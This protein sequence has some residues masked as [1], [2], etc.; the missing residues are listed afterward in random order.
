MSETSI[1]SLEYDVKSEL[2]GESTFVDPRI[3]SGMSDEIATVFASIDLIDYR[4]RGVTFFDPKLIISPSNGVD[5][6]VY[7]SLD[8]EYKGTYD[9][10]KESMVE[11]VVE[12]LWR[13]LKQE[14]IRKY[15]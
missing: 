9:R 13:H 6:R 4:R 10:A 1:I 3:V 15:N 5:P 14:P 7:F 8:V 11:G 2:E 12:R